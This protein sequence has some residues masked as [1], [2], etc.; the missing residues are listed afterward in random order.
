[1][2][3]HHDVI[4]QKTSGNEDIHY[5]CNVLVID[6]EGIDH[7]RLTPCDARKKKEHFV[8]PYITVVFDTLSS[9]LRHNVVIF[10]HSA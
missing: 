3:K 4:W 5:S 1:M 7:H 8:F 6:G 2:G 9:V 10:L